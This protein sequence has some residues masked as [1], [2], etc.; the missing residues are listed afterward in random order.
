MPSSV[1]TVDPNQ[2]GHHQKLAHSIK[3]PTLIL[4]TYIDADQ[5]TPCD[6]NHSVARFQPSLA[7]AST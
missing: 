1:Q 4:L 5:P 3:Q 6:L 7:S 2:C